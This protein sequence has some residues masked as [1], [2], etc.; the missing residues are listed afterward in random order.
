MAIRDVEP[1]MGTGGRGRGPWRPRGILLIS[2]LLGGLAGSARAEERTPPPDAPLREK[3]ERHPW[4][5]VAE[6]T[7][8]NLTL[9]AFDRYVTG[10]SWA[11]VDLHTWKSN[12]STGFVWD[13]DPFSENQF[14]HPYAGS[15]YFNAARDNGFSF[16]GATPFTLLGSLQW[17]L[18]AENDPASI[19]DIIN[20]TLGGMAL[21]E[22]L[23]RLSSL[24]LDTQATGRER[25]GRELAGAMLSPIRGFNRLVRGDLSRHEPTPKDWRP[26][27]FA[28]WGSAGYLRLADGTSLGRGENQFFAQFGL[29][30]GDAFRGDVHKPFDAFEGYVRLTTKEHSVVSHARLTGV[31]A[32]HTLHWTEQDALRLGLFQELGYMDTLAYE[33]GGQSLAAGLLH[34]RTLGRDSKLKL[35]LMV[36]GDVLVGISS[37]HTGSADRNYDYGPGV[38]LQFQA[39]YSR[40]GWD[41]VTLEAGVSH[42]DAVSGPGGVHRVHIGQL[43]V[44]V[45]VR[46]RLGLGSEV[47]Y[48]RRHSRFHAFPDVR[49]DAY[50]LRVFVSLH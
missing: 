9:W 42:I 39:C 11:R 13:D 24:V 6:V 7:G 8:I 2:G 16:L 20:T 46:G 18:F 17:E 4:L 12:L 48:F 26:E 10:K 41:I 49:K 45:P 32:A 25:F 44:D 23:Y 34:Q 14:A 29:R 35:A 5:T 33:L 43:Q 1:G 22:A 3:K 28:S 50:E 36:V 30:Y 38:G 40:D 31:L 47:N 15:L 37:E 21:G 27:S 19:N